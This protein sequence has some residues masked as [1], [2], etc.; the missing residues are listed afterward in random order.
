MGC[1]AFIFMNRNYE[2]DHRILSCMLK[3]YKNS[4]QNYQLLFFPEGTD[5]G[6]RATEISNS[7]ADKNGF[8]RYD[9]VLHPRTTG[10]NYIVNR[11]KKG[12]IG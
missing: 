3:Y 12:Y 9:Y 8:P 4:L 11:M 7:Y 2:Q 5:R 1:G 10:F 6:E